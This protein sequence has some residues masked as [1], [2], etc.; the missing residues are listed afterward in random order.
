MPAL[1]SIRPAVRAVA[2]NP[3]LVGV[4]ALFALAQLPDLLVGPTADPELSAAVSALTF[5]ILVLVA[6]FFQGGLL[7][8]ADEALDARTRLAT[9][10]T[11]GRDHYL[12]L[13][14]AYFAL[15]GVSLAFGFLAFFGVL[16]GLAGNLLSEPAGFVAVPA[17][18]VTLVAVIAIIAVG[19]FGAYLLV[20]FFLQFYA[21]AIVVDDAELVAAFRRSFR[22]VR[23]NLVVTFVYTVFLTAGGAAFGLFV[24]AASL[25]LAAPTAIGDAPTWVPA[26]EIGTLAG[27]GVGVGAVAVTGVLGA[28]WATY[29][30]AVYRALTERTPAGGR[31]A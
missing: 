14:V 30:V 1:R 4:S 27:V 16:L 18:N 23:S 25:T 12:P 13:L 5:G 22:V 2:R 10:V 7:A 6:P 24:A 3:V 17:E 31:G 8:M 20:T 28:L 15:L 9:L 26:V 19:L 11:A 21:H 29:S